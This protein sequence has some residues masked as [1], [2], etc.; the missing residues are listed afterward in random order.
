M[1]NMHC[2]KLIRSFGSIVGHGFEKA[3]NCFLIITRNAP[4]LIYQFLFG[5]C[6]QLTKWCGTTASQYES[7][8]SAV[9]FKR[10]NITKVERIRSQLIV[11]LCPPTD[12]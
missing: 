3:T 7:R 12:S 1:P 6:K 11:L 10:G 2:Y 9:F 4:E 5:R 8:V